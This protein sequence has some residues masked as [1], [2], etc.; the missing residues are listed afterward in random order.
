MGSESGARVQL[1]HLTLAPSHLT[2]L[3]HLTLTPSLT[4]VEFNPLGRKT[5]GCEMNETTASTKIREIISANS[6]F[7]GMKEEHL[8]FLVKNAHFTH[9][10]SGE[11]L[12][13]QGQPAKCFYLMISGEVTVGVPAI[14]GP[15]LQLQ[16]LTGGQMI[17][18]SWLIDPY[19]WDF[20][21]SVIS[22]AEL[23][24]FNGEAILKHC[25]EDNAFGYALYKRFTGLMSERLNSARRK[26]MDQWDAPGFA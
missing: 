18:W 3:W 8:D 25:E 5:I 22:E 14:Q 23:I 11:V 17:G 4:R 15:V 10:D 19:R 2:P 24:E 21:A 26:M 20:Q 13:R 1:W 9:V 16:E 6:F 7:A 12:F